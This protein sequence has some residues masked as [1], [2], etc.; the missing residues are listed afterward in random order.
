LSQLDFNFSV[1]D[2]LHDSDHYP[3]LLNSTVPT[4]FPTSPERFNFN[5][6]D[7]TI[8]KTLT[9]I[10][11]E[12]IPSDDI[13]Y[14]LTFIIQIIIA[15]AY[16]AIPLKRS[17]NTKRPVPWFNDECRAACRLRNASE[18]KLKRQNSLENRISY[19]RDK[20]RCRYIIKETR[21]RYWM[22]YVSSINKRISLHAVWKKV[23]KIAGRF[24]SSPTPVLRVPDGERPPTSS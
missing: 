20:A 16:A 24:N 6:A 5:K 15:A 10:E 12:E 18:R 7:W 9:N 14:F 4:D 13:N 23:S 21:R 19:K 2:N 11:N 22:K 17:K 1:L 3:I 8:F